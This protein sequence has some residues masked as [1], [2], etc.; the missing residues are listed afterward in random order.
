MSLT[1]PDQVL[2]AGAALVLA[3]GATVTASLLLSSPPMFY[4]AFPLGVLGIFVAAAGYLMEE[5][6]RRHGHHAPP[7][8]ASGGGARLAARAHRQD[9]PSQ[10]GKAA[11]ADP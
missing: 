1:R 10:S 8:I 3:A 6:E 4:V 5:S 2:V 11:S 9:L 7:Q